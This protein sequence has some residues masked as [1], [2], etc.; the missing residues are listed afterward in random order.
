MSVGNRSILW[1]F[2]M[3]ASLALWAGEAEVVILQTTDVH[4]GG[5]DGATW[6]Q[7]ATVIKR[8]RRLAG[9]A[10]NV[11]L[12]DCGDT[13]QGSLGTT[14]DRG[15]AGLRMLQHL[16]Y[17]AWIPGN[18]ELDFGV[19]H[20]R[21]LTDSAGLPVLNGNLRLPARTPF[22]ASRVFARHGVKVAVIGM[23]NAKLRYWVWGK[24]MEGFEVEPAIP[25]LKRILPEVQRLKPHMI[26]L[27]IHQGHQ[28]RSGNLRGEVDKIARLFPQIDLI[29]GGH[30]HRTIPG[31]RVAGTYYVQPAPLGKQVARVRARVDL[32]QRRVTRFES[33]LLATANAPADP[34]AQR[35]L[36]T[37]MA[38]AKLFGRQKVC[39]TDLPISARGR[40]GRGCHMSEVISRALAW[41]T[42]AVAVFHPVLSRSGWDKGIITE[43]DLFRAVPYENGIG[44]ASL[45]ADQ[46]KAILIEQLHC[47]TRGY[48]NGLWG[49]KATV[50]LSRQQVHHLDFPTG[51][52][53][54]PV[55][56]SSYTIA[57][58]GSRFPVLHQTVRQPE[59]QLTWVA[60]ST[61]DVL[62]AYL[63]AQ[64]DWNRPPVRWLLGRARKD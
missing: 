36:K 7:L 31:K 50:S 59:A 51:T 57:G 58:A 26:V 1:V 33:V 25:L 27:A 16:D 20:L 14:L 47:K 29:L 46:I 62:R 30:T 39:E 3:S 22:P 35:I 38:K 53:R 10:D 32:E 61:R 9:G 48:Q 4:G 56:F 45:T 18:H 43:A 19:K 13:I 60:P 15:A 2:V 21:E 6:L 52:E 5:A 41:K 49:I 8:E 28:E 64:K 55:A 44:V 11:L 42:K 34:E 63:R 17:S 12:L 23:N 37:H 24:P 54:I 40:P